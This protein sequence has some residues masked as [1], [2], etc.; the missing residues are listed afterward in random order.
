[1]KKI[2]FL[3]LC[4]FCVFMQTEAQTFDEETL[5]GKW[6]CTQASSPIDNYLVSMDSLGLGTALWDQYET[7]PYDDTRTAYNRFASGVF[8]GK[9]NE[10]FQNLKDMN[11]NDEYV[12]D[13]FIS[14]ND[15]L[16]IGVGDD[17]TL[18]FKIISLT[19]TEMTLQ[20]L[21]GGSQIHF[22]KV[23]DFSTGIQN[24]KAGNIGATKTYYNVN[25]Q[26]LN[27]KERGVTIV[28]QINGEA[29]KEIVR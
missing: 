5:V 10:Q 17:F 15:K 27:G 22:R 28:R 20:T 25:G 14:N 3:T 19:S 29:Y 6:I 21:N 13:F 23:E 11:Y 24:T 9:W 16:H 7:D 4:L 12:R 2:L 8:Y 1:M 18:I 26:K